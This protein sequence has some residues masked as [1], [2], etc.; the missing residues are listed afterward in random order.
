[1]LCENGQD[2]YFSNV[3]WAFI[4]KHGL[5]VVAG[6]AL[7]YEGSACGQWAGKNTQHLGSGKGMSVMQQD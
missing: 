7:L 3:V 5:F 4:L 1:M 2:F 6:F